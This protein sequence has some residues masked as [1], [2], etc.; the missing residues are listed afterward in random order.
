MGTGRLTGH[1]RRVRNTL[2]LAFA[3]DHP[4]RLIAASFALGLFVTTLPTLGAGIPV[5]AWIGYRFEWA[6]R[7]ALFSA[8]V[9][10][11]PLA[12]AGVYVASFVVGVRLLGPVEGVTHLDVGLDAGADVLVR[13]L[14]GNVLLAVVFT[15]AGYVLVYKVTRSVHR[16]K[17]S[18]SD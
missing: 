2:R 1:L 15:V 8:V 12:K 17:R 7:L 16:R 4:P 11:N 9:V 18:G 6:N 5:L 10:L 14:V 13:L 3:E